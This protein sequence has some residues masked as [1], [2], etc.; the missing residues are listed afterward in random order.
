MG[1]HV[2]QQGTGT[3]V[4]ML[5][6]SGLSGRQW[7]RLTPEVVRRG[8]RA[9]VPDLT[10]HG[11]SEPWPEPVPF[12]FRTD[13]DRVLEILQ[14]VGAAHVVGHSYGGLL[15]LHAA[16]RAPEMLR[17]LVLYEPVA[18]GALHPTEDAD[19]RATLATVE[20]SWGATPSDHDA[21]LR[22]F[23]DYWGGRD[24]WSALREEA[25]AEFRRVGW[26]LHEGVRTLTEDTTPAKTFALAVKAPVRLFTAA[27][28]PIAAQRVVRRL[29]EA[30][31]DA[32]VTTIAGVGHM[33]PV[34]NA[35]VVTPLLLGAIS[36]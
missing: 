20:M 12:S 6:S 10:G 26:V 2:D 30:F 22:G 36:L 7:R 16:V 24:A 21:W 25:R 31:G 19:A 11:Q 8:L 27:L 5:H 17:S 15:A 9:V 14:D 34:A 23:V 32:T 28:S 35:D 3:P 1:L 33:G 29:G 13:V 18:L 4:V